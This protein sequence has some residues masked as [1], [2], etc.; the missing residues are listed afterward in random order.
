MN[1]IK[2]P[3]CGQTF[4]ED[5]AGYAD[6]LKQARD[7]QFENEINSRLSLANQEKNNAIKIVES[8]SKILLQKEIAKKDKEI[9]NL[10]AKANRELIEKISE[11]DLELTKLKAKIKNSETDK[12]LAISEATKE[13]EKQRDSLENEIKTKELEK[14]NLK[15]SLEQKYLIEL[16][17]KDEIIKYKDDEISRFKDL[18]QK[19]STKMVG[20]SLEKHCENEFNK[21][22]AAA[23]Q[24]VYFER[25]NDASSGTK[26]DYI[27]R[28]NDKGGNEIISIMLSTNSKQHIHG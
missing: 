11:K 23:F 19:L 7:K 26:G 12:N 8:N 27:Y 3:K 25:D 13:V 15:S 5:N 24:N 28:E 20:E 22:R 18:K 14:L 17:N 10:K 4:H 16:Q 6:I 21:I 2:C 1:E 9:L